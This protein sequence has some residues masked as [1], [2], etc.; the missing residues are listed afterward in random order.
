MYTLVNVSC[1]NTYKC[2]L[3]ITDT[4]KNVT[5]TK[6]ISPIIIKIIKI[7][8]RTIAKAPQS[9]PPQSQLHPPQSHPLHPPHPLQQS[10]PP[11][12]QLHP[13]VL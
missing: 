13:V 2:L 1:S 9:P 3:R 11:Q 7:I 8:K 12:S 6:A 10:H 5:N 4:K